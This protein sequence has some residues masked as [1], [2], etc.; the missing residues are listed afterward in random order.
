LRHLLLEAG[1]SSVEVY[2]DWD[3]SPYDQA[4]RVLI[5]VARK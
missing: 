2:G 1:F 4:A 5:A 3:G